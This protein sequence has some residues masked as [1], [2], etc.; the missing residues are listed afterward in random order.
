[1]FSFTLIV[2]INIFTDVCL[3]KTK[4]EKPRT[5]SAITLAYSRREA[6]A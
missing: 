3:Y 1:M 6:N 2:E 5:A 4:Q